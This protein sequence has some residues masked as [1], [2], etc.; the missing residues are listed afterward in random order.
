MFAHLVRYEVGQA[1][2]AESF[3]DQVMA[4]FDAMQHDIPGLVGSFLL[5]RREDGEALQITLWDTEENARGAEAAVCSG[6]APD[7]G[8]REV[9]TGRRADI[10]G[11]AIWD[12]WQGRQEFRTD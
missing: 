10:A 9:V 5:T 6:P 11:T 8:A 7:T 1:E 3:V 4:G 12:V 2:N